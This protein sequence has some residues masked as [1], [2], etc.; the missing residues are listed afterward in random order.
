MSNGFVTPVKVVESVPVIVD[1]SSTFTAVDQLFAVGNGDVPGQAVYS[2]YGAND[3]I[4]TSTAPEDIKAGG[5]R[6]VW[7]QAA[8]PLSIVSTSANDTAGSSGAVTVLLRGLDASWNLITETINLNGLTPVITANNYIRLND[9]R[10]VAAGTY[11]GANIGTV[12][13]IQQTSL[14]ELAR[15]PVGD[16]VQNGFKFTIPNNKKGHLLQTTVAISRGSATTSNT[17]SYKFRSFI[18]ADDVTG[19]VYGSQNTQIVVYGVRGTMQYTSVYTSAIP[20]KTDLWVEIFDVGQ[21]DTQMSASALMLLID[22]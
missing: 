3:D 7:P 11:H 8:E 19:P 21:N 2:I 12:T 18:N 9:C 10:V 6:F 1:G 20:A 17:A 5:G 14:I 4:D 16:G 13:A 22:I 15:I